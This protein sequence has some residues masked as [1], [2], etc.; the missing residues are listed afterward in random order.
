MGLRSEATVIAVWRIAR[1]RSHAVLLQATGSLST[2]H[3]VRNLQV[4]RILP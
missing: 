4:R 1:L 3:R 2:S